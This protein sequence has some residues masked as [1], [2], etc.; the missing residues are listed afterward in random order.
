[1]LNAIICS[2]M[3]GQP[4]FVIQPRFCLWQF[5]GAHEN[6]LIFPYDSFFNDG[7]KW[8]TIIHKELTDA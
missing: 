1:M 6:L 7:L 3:V 5:F 4:I 2:K 8:L